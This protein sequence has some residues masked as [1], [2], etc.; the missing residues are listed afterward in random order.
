[1]NII[2]IIKIREKTISDIFNFLFTV[3]VLSNDR[4]ALNVINPENIGR[5]SS[6]KSRKLEGRGR[7]RV[8]FTPA[9]SPAANYPHFVTICR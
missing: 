2:E 7:T 4:R 3:E 5:S 1:M 9:G 8:V 6:N